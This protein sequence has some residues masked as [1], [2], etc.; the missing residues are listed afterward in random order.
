MASQETEKTTLVNNSED[1]ETMLNESIENLNS[2][3]KKGDVVVGKISSINESHII[4]SIGQKQDALAEI[5]DYLENGVLPLKVG[6]EIKGFIVKMVDDQITISKSLNRSHG[7]KVLVKE[8]F[9]KKIPVKG[10]VIESLKGG[11]SVD[12]F[13]IRAFCPLSHI[14]LH[15]NEKPE[16]YINNTY[17]FLIIEFEKGSIIL[18]RKSILSAETEE[19]KEKFFSRINVGDVVKGKVV[20]VTTYG[21]F[22]DLG[23]FEGLLHISELSWTHINKANEVINVGDEIDV[24]I[25]KIENDKIS[26]SYRALHENPMLVAMNKLKIGDTVT[27]KVIRHGSFG[28]FV[29]IEKGVEGLIPISL[30]SQ[31]RINK[32]SEVLNIGDEIKAKI[33]KLDTENLKISLTLREEV[34][35]PWVIDG[36]DLQIGM[37]LNGVIENITDHGAFIKVKNTLT[38]LMPQFKMKRA[39]LNLKQENIGDEIQ[40]RVASFDIKSQRL[41]LEPLFMPELEVRTSDRKETRDNKDSREIREPREPRE[42]QENRKQNRDYSQ[43]QDWKKYATNYQSVPEDNPFNDL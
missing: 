43:D 2:N 18:S 33:L 19:K 41:S 6:E 11:Y 21:A 10:K 15:G 22:I 5:G 13:G 34:V 26:L 32:P 8:A 7:N 31:K 4:I 17:D 28:S 9:T 12:V 40:V 16:A 35:N 14:D 29:E 39:K 24:K 37:E 1:F 36:A 38:G 27:C 3:F 30:I 42:R 23:G 20:R 25:L